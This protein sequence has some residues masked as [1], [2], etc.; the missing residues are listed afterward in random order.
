MISFFSSAAGS[1][2]V[3]LTHSPQ[4]EREQTVHACNYAEVSA[5]NV[6]F[7]CSEKKC[8][9]LSFKHSL[10]VRL[11]CMARI[12][13]TYSL[14]LKPSDAA[15]FVYI[16]QPQLRLRKR[17]D[18]YALCVQ[19]V[20]NEWSRIVRS[21][22]SLASTASQTSATIAPI[23]VKQG[24]VLYV[25][26]IVSASTTPVVRLLDIRARAHVERNVLYTADALIANHQRCHAPWPGVCSNNA[27][28]IIRAQALWKRHLSF[29]SMEASA[30][31]LFLFLF[32]LISSGES[33]KK[34]ERPTLARRAKNRKNQAVRKEKRL[35]FLRC[36][37]VRSDATL[38][39][40]EKIRAQQRQLMVHHQQWLPCRKPAGGC[41]CTLPPSPPTRPTNR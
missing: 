31:L 8:N 24:R 38:K 36:R 2:H 10:A 41:G 27:R 28:K 35:M 39:A 3:P 34:R 30:S 40:K 33:R 9:T 13:G 5:T 19:L 25:S 32:I 11:R 20:N 1:W 7:A 6:W 15:R 12:L 37:L 22:V 26:S 14:C 4:N 23:N 29:R 16:V 18:S 21:I 17:V